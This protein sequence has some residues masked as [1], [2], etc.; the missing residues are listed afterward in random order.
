MANMSVLNPVNLGEIMAGRFVVPENVIVPGLSGCGWK[1]NGIGKLGRIGQASPC[2]AAY[3]PGNCDSVG[4]TYDSDNEVCNCPSNPTSI[5]ATTPPVTT[6]VG[7][8]LS[9]VG[10]AAGSVVGSTASGLFSG[11]ASSTGIPTVAWYAGL[12]FLAYMLIKK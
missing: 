3:S 10:S 8:G 12:A 1:G 6:M 2:S 11:L 4:G 7:Q 9:V 5:I